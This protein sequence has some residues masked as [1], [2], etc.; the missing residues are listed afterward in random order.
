MQLITLTQG[1]YLAHILRFTKSKKNFHG[2]Q[3][4]IPY[5]VTRSIEVIYEMFIY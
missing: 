1:K 4:L 5:L 3:P 2:F